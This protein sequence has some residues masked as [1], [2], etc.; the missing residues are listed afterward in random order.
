MEIDL[1]LI[2]LVQILLNEIVFIGFKSIDVFKANFFFKLN[3]VK[4]SKNSPLAYSS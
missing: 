3:Q 1:I 4:I 2:A